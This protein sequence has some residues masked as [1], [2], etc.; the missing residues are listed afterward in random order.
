MIDSEKFESTCKQALQ[1]LALLKP[2]IDIVNNLFVSTMFKDIESTIGCVDED[3]HT[4]SSWYDWSMSIID[5]LMQIIDKK[6]KL[7][8]DCLMQLH[9]ICS[10]IKSALD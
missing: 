2:K 1:S 7:V 5:S 6:Q 3:Y 10:T 9:K 4:D 8:I